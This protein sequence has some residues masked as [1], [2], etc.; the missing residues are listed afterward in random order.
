MFSFLSYAQKE[1]EEKVPDKVLSA[2][3]SKFPD[4]KK[5]EW[6]MEGENEWE[7]EFKLN[8]KKYSSNFSTNGKWMETEYAIKTSEIP[9]NINEI[10][11]QNFKD[12]KIEEAEIS[13]T[14]S[15]KVYEFEIEVDDEEYDVIINSQGKLTKQ[16]E[17]E[18][19][20]HED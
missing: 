3:K 15:E 5:V 12:F 20:D 14:A 7:A 11:N 16:K 9:E 17:S 6:E 1:Q 4:A 13:E 18:N 2:F 19:D 10:L 8:G